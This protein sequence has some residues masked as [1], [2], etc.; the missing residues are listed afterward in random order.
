MLIDPRCD[1]K[2]FIEG[3]SCSV[4]SASISTAVKL[5]AAVEVLP[6]K[7]IRQIKPMTNIVIG[8]RDVSGKKAAL[9]D[10]K[11]TTYSVLFVGMVTGMALTKSGTSRSASLSCCLLYTSPSPRDQRGSRMPS[12][13]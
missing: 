1:L 13:A 7:Q 5:T 9:T 11:G 3:Y 6:T 4:M 2:L 8:Y 10:E 12:S